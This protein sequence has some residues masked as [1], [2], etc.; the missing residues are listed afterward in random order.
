MNEYQRLEPGSV[1]ITAD[2]IVVERFMFI[3]M[4]LE[5]GKIA[6]LRW[7]ANRIQDALIDAEKIIDLGTVNNTVNPR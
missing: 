1:I 7:A 6:A 3:G 5:Q 2:S 4:T